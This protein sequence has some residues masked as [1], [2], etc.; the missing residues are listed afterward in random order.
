MNLLFVFSDLFDPGGEFITAIICLR[1]EAEG[2]YPLFRSRSAMASDRIGLTFP[3]GVGSFVRFHRDDL[4][5]LLGLSHFKHLLS[6]GI[7]VTRFPRRH[8]RGE[9]SRKASK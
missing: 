8:L 7:G 4:L 1:R 5:A 3:A 2:I 6:L 9:A